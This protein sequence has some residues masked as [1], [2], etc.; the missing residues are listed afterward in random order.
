MWRV[1][2]AE[3]R[4]NARLDKPLSR[5]P[6]KHW[7]EEGMGVAETSE[8]TEKG[9]KS[10]TKHGTLF[11]SQQAAEEVEIRRYCNGRQT[12]SLGYLQRSSGGTGHS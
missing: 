5:G 3:K 4:Y 6:A 7:A 11:S 9:S 8:E 10:R 2:R 1:R 12:G